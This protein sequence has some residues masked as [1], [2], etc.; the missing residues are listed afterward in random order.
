MLSNKEL[1]LVSGGGVNA[2]DA[3]K[4]SVYAGLAC[5]GVWAIDTVIKDLKH[6]RLL[7]AAVKTAGILTLGTI[8]CIYLASDANKDGIVR[9]AGNAAI[10]GIATLTDKVI[11]AFSDNQK[12]REIAEK[13]RKSQGNK[14]I[15]DFMRGADE[16]LSN[17][18][19][20]CFSRVA[21]WV[22]SKFSSCKTN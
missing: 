7:S 13:V 19:N 8:S 18:A 11:F 22:I 12:D 6:L 2:H 20:L 17:A 9:K 3:G 14:S 5:L 1:E 10:N 4:Y 21:D 15:N 16:G